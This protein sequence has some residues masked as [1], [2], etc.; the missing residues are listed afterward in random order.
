VGA[1]NSNPLKTTL[2][3]ILDGAARAVRAC[4]YRAR[5]IG[6]AVS[7]DSSC[8]VSWRSV[9]RTSGGGSISIGK[10]CEIHPFAMILTYGGAIAVGQNCSLN[11]FVIVYG[12][13][14]V[15]I[16]NGVRIAAH[17]VIIPANHNALGDGTPFHRSGVSAK[18]IKIGDDVWIGA[19]A[20][21]LDGVTLESHSVIGA[22]SVVTK[23]VAAHTIVAGVPARVIRHRSQGSGT[24]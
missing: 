5:F 24:S 16:G 19:G 17:T 14:G 15:E 21:I 13:G 7:I 6:R 3:R 11:P 18:G 22:G 1:V 2:L 8:R 20:R 9:I 23:S 10:N 4:A 12:H